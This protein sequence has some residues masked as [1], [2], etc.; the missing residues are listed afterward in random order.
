[1]TLEQIKIYFEKFG[2]VADCQVM[3]DHST[4]RSRGFAFVTYESEGS[5]ENALA[6]GKMHEVDGK[7][8]NKLGHRTRV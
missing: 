8:V 6:Q 2:K 7:Q 5:V 3:Q 4:G 1:L